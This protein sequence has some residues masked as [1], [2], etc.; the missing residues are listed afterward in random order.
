MEN[1][2][3][4]SRKTDLIQAENIFPLIGTLYNLP[5]NGSAIRKQVEE[6]KIRQ[7]TLEKREIYVELPSDSTTF[8]F[9]RDLKTILSKSQ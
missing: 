9:M 1:E 8:K 5:F 4:A 6:F 7:S 2:A 3:K